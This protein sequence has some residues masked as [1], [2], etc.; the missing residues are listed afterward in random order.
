M[1]RKALS[2]QFQH[3]GKSVVLLGQ[4]A[5]SERQCFL[6]SFLEDRQNGVNDAWWVTDSDKKEVVNSALQNVLQQYVEVFQEHIRLPPMRSQVHQIKLFTDHGPEVSQDANIQQIIQEVTTKPDARPGYHVQQGILFY[7][8]RL[9]ISANSPSIPLLLKEFHSTPMGGHS[10]FLRTY[11]RIVTNLYWVGMQKSVRE[12]VRAC[13]VCQRQKYA[14]TTPGVVALE[15][16][17]RDEALKHLKAH[18]LRAQQQTKK[19]AD[20]KRRDLKFEVGEWVFLKLRPHRQQ[21]VVKRINQK[22]DARFY[23][24]F[25]VLQKIGE[26]AYKLELPTQS[27]IHPVFHVSLLKKVVG[28]YQVQGEL[29]K[30]LEVVGTDDIYPD[31]VLGTRLTVQADDAYLRGQFPE[32]S[33]ED[34][35]GFKEGGVDRDMDDEGLA[36]SMLAVS[37]QGVLLAPE[38]NM[39]GDVTT[40]NMFSNKSIFPDLAKEP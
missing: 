30:E 36:R 11:R 32:F 18:L 34:K 24:P 40:G 17:E 5:N 25:K 8:G 3:E 15:L 19:Y 39:N 37:G 14:A 22:L 6:N 33:L 20:S 27:K 38:V 35:A 16:S 23:G 7:Q 9:V 13:D 28:N 1:D 31:K 2:M 10:G 4:G 12:F 29:P 21:S 26:V